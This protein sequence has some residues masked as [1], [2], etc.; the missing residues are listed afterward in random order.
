MNPSRRASEARRPTRRRWGQALGLALGA[1]ALI[2]IAGAAVPPPRPASPPK[3]PARSTP[4]YLPNRG[5]VPTLPESVV[6]RV[7]GRADITVRELGKA[8]VRLARTQ[9]PD[10]LGPERRREVL[11]VLIEKAVLSRRA[12]RERWTWSREE[13]TQYKVL[14]D[15]LTLS[16]ALDSTEGRLR[17]RMMARGDTVPAPEMLGMAARDSFVADLA[18]RFDMPL[19]QR[20]AVAFDTLPRPTTKMPIMEQMR[21]AGAMPAPDPSDL[22]RPVVS[23]SVGPFTVRD[24]LEA[25]G[26]LNPIYRPR[27]KTAADVAD[28][29]R[30][31]VYERELRRR[32]VA[33][34]YEERPEVARVLAEQ[35]EL[36]AV[37]HYVQREVYDRIPLDSLTL[38]RHYERK[39][40]QWDVPPKAK[41]LEMELPDRAA[42]MAM[43]ERI[44]SGAEAESLQA[45]AQ[46]AGT[47]FLNEASPLADS[48]IYVFAA[49]EGPGAV[50]GPDSTLTGF[51]II[52][53]M[54]LEPKKRRTFAEARKLVEKDWTDSEAERRMRLLLDRLRAQSN[55]VVDEK[56][57]R[58]AR[59]PDAPPRRIETFSR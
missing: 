7:D 14:R 20:L 1:L 25:W 49:R 59:L 15:R 51:R 41:T 3:L 43:M 50:L 39:L 24:M 22:D 42:A 31:G 44:R 46:R 9:K 58:T 21:L 28:L 30:N 40:D 47:S 17:A 36:F 27:V 4:V 45:Q 19:M 38:R 5:P 35:R 29:A 2:S 48:M 16:A 32:A 10:T 6:A 55:V 12:S 13:S 8:A 37:T 26:R 33:Q 54:S 23:T 56:R 18:P 53:V 34:R 11:N 52:R 57:L